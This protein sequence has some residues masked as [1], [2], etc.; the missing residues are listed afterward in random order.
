VNVTFRKSL[1]W[2]HT[3][4]GLTLG[5]VIVMLAV[6]GAGLVVRLQLE[7]AVNRDLLEVPACTARLSLDEQAAR[8]RTA[9]ALSPLRSIEVTSTETSS[10]AIQFINL[11]YVYIDPCSGAVL[12]IQNE[13]GGFFGTLD[14]WHRFRFMDRTPGHLIA[15]WVTVV[16]LLILVVGGVILWWPRSKA[17]FKGAVKFNPRLPGTARTL[18]LHKV[19][20]LYSCLM[21]VL[22]T[23]TALPISFLSVKETIYRV[24]GYEAPVDPTSTIQ[25]SDDYFPMEAAWHKTLQ[26][27]PGAEWITLNYPQS[28]ERPIRIEI[29]EP[30]R[31][32]INAKSYLFLD[33]WTG[34]ELEVRHYATDTPPGRKIYLYSIALHAALVG[35]L[36]YQLVMLLAALAIPVQAYS[37]FSPYLRRK[38]RTQP[39]T[40]MSL[41]LINKTVEAKDVCSFE[42]ADPGGNA[43]PGFSAGS[44]IDIHLGNGMSRQYSLCN[45][46]LDK[47]RYVIGVLRD[48]ESRGGSVAMHDALSL[49]DRVEISQPKNHFPLAHGAGQSVLIAG[50]IGITPIL[51]MAERL[52]NIGSEFTMH[53]CVR[54]LDRAAFLDRIRQSAFSDQVELHVSDQG[55]R[56]NISTLLA[57]Y[58]PET[59]V[60]VC[61]PGR[62]MDAVL[63]AAEEM[64]WP[65]S[66]VH[67]EYFEATGHDLSKDCPFDVKI[68]STGRVIHIPKDK[69]VTTVL[70]ECGIDIPTSCSEGVCA[71]CITHVL[72]GEIEHNDMVLNAEQRAKNDQFMPCCS[73][74]RGPMLVLDL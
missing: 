64:G 26:R 12:G 52:Y 53:Y 54:S 6:T 35:G 47:H 74:A 65:D 59:H 46:P 32:H 70:A 41:K 50:G 23:I 45:D 39:K 49:G 9:H 17:A 29:R 51:C 58:D 42:F 43:L 34:E 13:Y 18:S 71:T 28:P 27:F 14:K 33:A 11:D 16:F 15:G 66:Q 72:E 38:F 8:A 57:T 63:S 56:L 67:R 3:W 60:Y 7:S 2:L 40:T 69:S 31:P 1:S 21:L 68:A 19:I 30:G 36:P 5:L 22:I 62:L 44:H 73:R 61:G 4:S 37:G 24:A 55:E 20:G 10:T 48:P 25:A